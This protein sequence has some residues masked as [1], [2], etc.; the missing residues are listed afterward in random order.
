MPYQNHYVTLDNNIVRS[1]PER[2][3]HHLLIDNFGNNVIYEP[4]YFYDKDYDNNYLPDWFISYNNKIIIIEYYGMLNMNHVDW[5]Y[6]DKY[7]LKHNYYENI[8]KRKN[9]K[10]KYIE[11]IKEDLNNG[12]IGIIDKF[13]NIGIEIH[14]N[15]TY[16]K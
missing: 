4:K 15:I 16:Y 9:S 8:C 10:Y 2:M 5:G 3:I 14:N 6:D 11:I 1:E 7:L 12:M 13:K